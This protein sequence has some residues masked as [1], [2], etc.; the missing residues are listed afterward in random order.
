MEM[1]MPVWEKDPDVVLDS[2]VEEFRRVLETWAKGRAEIDKTVDHFSKATQPLE[3]PALRIET[4]PDLVSLGEFRQV[5]GRLRPRLIRDGKE[6]LRWER[7][8]TKAMPLP[9]GQYLLAT[10]EIVED[11]GDRAAGR[12]GET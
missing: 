11:D 3:W 1:R 9:A 6:Y 10:G 4:D 2:P 5:L 12:P 7:P 8:A